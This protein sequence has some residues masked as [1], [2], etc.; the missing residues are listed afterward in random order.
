MRFYLLLPA[1]ALLLSACASTHHTARAN[2]NDP[3]PPKREF[4]AAW[5]ATVGNI[6]WPSRPGLSTDEQNF[7]I[8]FLESL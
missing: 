7:I 1:I 6:D 5:V 8:T 3:P 2:N 4:R